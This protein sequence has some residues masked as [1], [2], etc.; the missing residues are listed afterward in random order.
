MSE[1]WRQKAAELEARLL[2]ELKLQKVYIVTSGQYDEMQLEAAF[3]TALKADG[4]IFA[5]GDESLGVEEL[6]LDRSWQDE[7]AS[8]QKEAARVE[9]ELKAD[10]PYRVI[11]DATLQVWGRSINVRV[12]HGKP[13][14]MTQGPQPPIG[15]P[16]AYAMEYDPALRSDLVAEAA[17][18]WGVLVALG[19]SEQHAMDAIKTIVHNLKGICTGKSRAFELLI[20]SVIN[21]RHLLEHPLPSDAPVFRESFE[22]MAW[23]A[24]VDSCWRAVKK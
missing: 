13:V 17:N 9:A 14:E 2:G 8:I 15:N 24:L 6:F 18:V 16:F 11:R 5:R 1:F 3:T 4:Y 20:T 12:E 21:G 23:L 19:I 22:R 10:L 7:F